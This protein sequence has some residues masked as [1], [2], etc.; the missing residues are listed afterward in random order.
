MDGLNHL[1]SDHEDLI[2]SQMFLAYPAGLF[3]S[4]VIAAELQ[5]QT[6]KKPFSYPL[7]LNMKHE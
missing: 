6:E 2:Q 3:T 5:K 7:V 4:L 1:P